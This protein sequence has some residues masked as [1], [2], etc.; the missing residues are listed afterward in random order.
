M[1]HKNKWYKHQWNV[2]KSGLEKPLR[3]EVVY[4]NNP[5]LQQSLFIVWM[6]VLCVWMYMLCVCCKCVSWVKQLRPHISSNISFLNILERL[7][8]KPGCST[9]VQQAVSIWEKWR[10]DYHSRAVGSTSGA[11]TPK[12]EIEWRLR[13]LQQLSGYKQQGP[14][15]TAT[16]AQNSEVPFLSLYMLSH[17][18]HHPTEG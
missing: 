6:Y 11:K 1:V 13:K 8:Q 9:A 17:S 12:R 4:S 16:S 14:R 18:A 10:Q 7:C 5:Y 2:Y 15:G 3:E